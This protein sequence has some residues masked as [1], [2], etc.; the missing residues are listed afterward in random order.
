MNVW[1]LTKINYGLYIVSST[2]GSKINAQCANT[3]FQVTSEPVRIAICINKQNLTHEYIS[4]S[5]VFSISVLSQ[6]TPFNLIGRFGFRSGRDFDKFQGI[7]YKIGKTGSPIVIDY[8]LA[9][10]ECKVVKSMDAGTH[11][12]FVGELVDADILKE[13]TPMTYDYYHRVVK[14]KEPRT[15]PT[16]I[17]EKKEV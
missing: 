6:E 4:K 16:F 15:A 2:N 1:A 9:Y 12:L 7:N 3:V 17:K 10:M 14:G 8:S 11:T 5:G 13:G